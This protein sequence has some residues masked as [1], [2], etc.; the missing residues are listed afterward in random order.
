MI[1]VY[2]SFIIMYNLF[3][4]YP[5]DTVMNTASLIAYSEKWLASRNQ[6]L[7]MR[8]QLNLHKVLPNLQH[9]QRVHDELSKAY[10]VQIEVTFFTDTIN[11]YTYY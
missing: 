8:E 1:D 4:V 2:L 3:D 6:V 7:Y 9:E 5:Q 10:E 11:N